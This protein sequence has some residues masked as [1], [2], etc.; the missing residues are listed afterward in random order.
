MHN[1]HTD[2]GV[3]GRALNNQT[4]ALVIGRGVWGVS[5][6][7]TTAIMRIFPWCS[8]TVRYA[9]IEEKE[10]EEEKKQPKIRGWIFPVLWAYSEVVSTLQD[11]N[12]GWVSIF[13]IKIERTCLSSPPRF[14]P[15]LC[16]LYRDAAWGR[17]TTGVEGA[18]RTV[19]DGP[20]LR[21]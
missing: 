10:R 3:S 18:S 4:A 15:L 2:P 21:H 20:H 5:T 7:A 13:M 6:A 19:A 1:P 12:V 14:T 11:H 16:C 17:A 9:N 8:L